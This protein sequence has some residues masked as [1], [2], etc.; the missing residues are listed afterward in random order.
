MDRV[1]PSGPVTVPAVTVELAAGE[2]AV[3]RGVARVLTGVAPVP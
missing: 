2:A 1:S 3:K